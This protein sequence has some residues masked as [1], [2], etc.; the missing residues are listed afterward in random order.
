MVSTVQIRMLSNKLLV[1]Y[2]HNSEE[3][4]STFFKGVLDFV[5]QPKPRDRDPGG[6]VSWSAV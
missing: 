5:F 6:L 4:N 2:L 1:R 3:E